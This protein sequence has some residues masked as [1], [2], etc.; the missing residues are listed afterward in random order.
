MLLWWF[1]FTLDLN[2]LRDSR[3]GDWMLRTLYCLWGINSLIFRAACVTW[4][5]GGVGHADC[6]LPFEHTQY[7]FLALLLCALLPSLHEVSNYVPQ[8]CGFPGLKPVSNGLYPIKSWAKYTF[9]FLLTCV[10]L[11]F[12][13]N[14]R[15]A[16]QCIYVRQI[17]QV[18]IKC[19]HFF[20]T[21]LKHLPFAILLSDP[22][23][24]MTYKTQFMTTMLFIETTN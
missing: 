21:Q 5:W 1:R 17:L 12:C 10:C 14:I 9:F 2:G 3:R 20:N 22:M 23:N 15:E 8:G 13:V 19:S 6:V 7:I 24:W 4:K 16:D 11:V 18:K